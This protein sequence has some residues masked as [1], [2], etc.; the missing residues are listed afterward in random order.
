MEVLTVA[1]AVAAP[2]ID[3]PDSIPNKF[4]RKKDPVRICTSKMT[5]FKFHIQSLKVQC[6]ISNNECEIHSQN[7]S[8]APRKRQ[9]LVLVFFCLFFAF[10]LQR[11]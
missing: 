3:S 11:Y 2:N 6:V 8:S 1:S 9:G 10:W 5:A 4:L 7:A